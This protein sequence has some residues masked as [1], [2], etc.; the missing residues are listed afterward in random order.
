MT[1]SAS[2]KVSFAWSTER[3][4]EEEKSIILEALQ[5][6][7]SGCPFFAPI[8]TL[9]L[10]HALCSFSI[11]CCA[12]EVWESAAKIFG[13]ARAERQGRPLQKRKSYLSHSTVITGP[14]ELVFLTSFFCFFLLPIN[15]VARMCVEI[16]RLFI[17]QLGTKH[18]APPGGATSKRLDWLE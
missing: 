7:L 4:S 5:V 16:F 17:V 3:V 15:T 9:D 2:K 6:R 11:L 12:G 10:S 14:L 13:R 8:R 18:L 1:F